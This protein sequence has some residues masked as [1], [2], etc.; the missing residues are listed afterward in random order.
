MTPQPC[1][2]LIANHGIEGDIHS[3]PSSPR[4]VLLVVAEAL[5]KFSLNPGQLRENIVTRR[6]NHDHLRSGRLLII[7]DSAVV[8]VTFSCEICHHIG[9][10]PFKMRLFEDERGFLSIVGPMYRKL[11]DLFR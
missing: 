3:D 1:L 10:F 8:R 6:L 2:K 7:G 9:P 11:A 5:D 4:Q